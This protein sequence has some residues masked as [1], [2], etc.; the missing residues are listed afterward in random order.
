MD[1][2]QIREAHRNAHEIVDFLDEHCP[3]MLGKIVQL[4]DHIDPAIEPPY[5][6]HLICQ[7]YRN[8]D[9]PPAA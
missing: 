7:L 1:T 9:Q 3:F 2:Q 8:G 6:L 5:I 4:M